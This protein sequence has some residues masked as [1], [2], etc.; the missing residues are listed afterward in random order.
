MEFGIGLINQDEIKREQIKD[1]YALNING[2]SFVALKTDKSFKF[3][4]NNINGR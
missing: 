4:R 3:K 2:Q 1:A